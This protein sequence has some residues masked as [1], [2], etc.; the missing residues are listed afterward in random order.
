MKVRQTT[1]SNQIRCR[2]S[3]HLA[4]GSPAHAGR[5]RKI[6]QTPELEPVLVHSL[7]QA[8]NDE[9]VGGLTGQAKS[10]LEEPVR[11][12]IQPGA[13]SRKAVRYPWSRPVDARLWAVGV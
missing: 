3:R 2:L 6:L 8:L 9:L 11:R 13:L 7:V 5:V 10:A 1:R 4:L 12:R